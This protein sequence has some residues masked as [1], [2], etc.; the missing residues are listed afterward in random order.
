MRALARV[1]T[2]AAPLFALYAVVS[3][4]PIMAL[5]FLLAAHLPPAGSAARARP[6]AI[7]GSA[8]R[9]LGDRSPAAALADLPWRLAAGARRSVAAGR[10]LRRPQRRGPAAPAPARPSRP[11]RLLRRRLRPAR[12]ARR[13]G[14]RR[15]PRR[16]RRRPRPIST[17]T[18]SA[19]RRRRVSAPSRSTCRSAPGRPPAGSGSSS[20]TSPT[21]RSSRRPPGC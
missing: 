13:R 11:R 6:G 15:R 2:S 18:L 3:L 9:P 19:R 10:Q 14:A 7:R 4:I 8:P 16:D 5:G 21:S 12:A 17:P 20:S 1:R